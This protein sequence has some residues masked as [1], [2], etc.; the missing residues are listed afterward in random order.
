LG[1]W[2]KLDDE[3]CGILKISKEFR[4][5]LSKTYNAEMLQ[6]FLTFKEVTHKFYESY[7]AVQGQAKII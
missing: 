7:K 2:S 1:R 6:E 4:V 3:V 5:R